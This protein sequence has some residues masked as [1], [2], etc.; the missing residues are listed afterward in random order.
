[1]Q[2]RAGD[3]VEPKAPA[4]DLQ[5]APADGK[6]VSTPARDLSQH[7]WFEACDAPMQL[8]SLWR[9]GDFQH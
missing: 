1:M 7:L 3:L 4:A 6:A 8:P 9:D 2:H 5:Q